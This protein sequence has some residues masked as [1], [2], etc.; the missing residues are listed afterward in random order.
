MVVAAMTLV[1][2]KN[3]KVARAHKMLSWLYQV[4]AVFAILILMF[5]SKAKGFD[6]VIELCKVSLFAGALYGLHRLVA[7]GAM[8]RREWARKTSIA[9]G[10]VMLFGFP[11]GTIIGVYLLMNSGWES[12]PAPAEAGR[13]ASESSTK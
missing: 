3:V 7:A 5:M 11:I 8:D 2:E 12:V 4:F 10:V 1:I 6:L 13:I 9:I